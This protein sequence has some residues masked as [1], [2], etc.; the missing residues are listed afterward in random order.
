MA[1]DKGYRNFGAYASATFGADAASQT[2]EGKR[3]LNRAVEYAQ[4]PYQIAAKLRAGEPLTPDE[5]EQADAV[6]TLARRGRL[7]VAAALHRVVGDG[8]PDL[9][10][11]DTWSDPAPTSV[12]FDPDLVRNIT[13]RGR[14]RDLV[15]HADAGVQALFAP[16]GERLEAILPSGAPLK[17]VSVDGDRITARYQAVS[18]HVE[19]F[20]GG[21]G[22]KPGPCPAGG[23]GEPPADK[24]ATLADRVRALP[25]AVAEKARGYVR[26]KYQKLEA[27]YGPRYATAILAAGLAGVPVPAPGAS[28]LTAAPV[29]L[30]AELHRMI[31]GQHADNLAGATLTKEQI[32][33]LGKEFVA[34]LTAQWETAEGNA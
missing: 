23:G 8:F 14:R 12:S 7:P 22:G 15:I 29:I 9:K 20:C 33:E 16:A 4:H 21:P 34:E 11:G 30:A 25:G 27:R 32:A 17:I 10:P 13:V 31:A 19:H 2:P 26:A 6:N 18:E 24:A 1:G 3:L 28:L 5:Q